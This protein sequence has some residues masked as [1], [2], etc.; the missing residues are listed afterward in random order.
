MGVDCFR[1]KIFCLWALLT[2]CY[3]I[4][5]FGQ[6]GNEWIDYN[7]PYFKI[8]VAKKGI[9]RL[10]AGTLLAAGVPSGIDPTRFQLFH[11]GIEQSI[12]VS[13]Q[14]NGQLDPAD[15]IEF[16]GLANDGTQD[17]Q[18][19]RP[20][21]VQPHKY[22]NLFS[23]TTSYFLTVGT[24]PGKRMLNFDEVNTNGQTSEVF[25]FDEKL[26]INTSQYS[27][28]LDID[29]VQSTFF[30]I[31][32]GWTG[33]QLLQGQ[34]ADYVFSGI[35]VVE[36]T[37]GVP[38]IEVLLVGRGPM[39]HR[40]EIYAGTSA[41]LVATVDF[42]GFQSY[43]DLLSIAWSDIAGD[44]TLPI[45][46]KCV[47][48]GSDPDRISA[49]Y[50]KL[51]YSQKTD[52]QGV[53]EKYF[54]LPAN[55]SGKSYLDIINAAPGVRMFDVT[56]PD[57]AIAIGSIAA[58]T[59][60]AMVPTNT[61]RN[62]YASNTII[63][64]AI[65]AVSFR[66]I[67]P[68]QHNY[69]IISHPFLRQPASGYS[70]PVAAY[71][72]Y[73]ASADGGGYDTLVVHI[74]Q[75]Y[76]QF[77][78][79]EQSPLAVFHFMKFLTDVSVPKYLLLIGKG[80]D[81]SYQYYRSP[82]AF[83]PYHDFVP[84]AGSP[85]SDMAFT[86]GMG[87]TT[88]EPAVPTGRI[89]AVKSE[90][91][92]AYLNKVKEM[93]ALPY[94]D[95]WRK[96]LIHL[97][98]GI[99]EGE[100][101]Q[102]KLDMQAFQTV[103]ED[104]YLGGKVSALAKHSKEI[105]QINIAEQVNKGVN[106]ITFLGHASPTLLDFEL[107]YVTDPVQGYHNKGKYPTLLMNG[108]QVGA[109]FLN[110]TLFGED[111]LVAKDRGA[112][113]FIAHSAYGFIGSLKKYTQTFYEVGY[114]DTTFLTK[115]LGDIQKETARRY[116]LTSEVSSANV[117]QVQQMVLLGD[118][119]VRLFGA[120]K[121]DLEINDNHV[122][123]HSFNGQPITA[124]T[125]SFAVNMIVRNFGQATKDTIRV[126]I[127]RT[128]ND[129]TTITY[130]SL[131]P[132]TKYSDTLTYIIRKAEKQGFGNNT[133][134]ITIDP[135]NILAE[136]TKA[137]N[138]ASKILFISLNGTKNLYPSDFAIVGSQSVSL[139]IQATDLLSGEREFHVEL[140]TANSFDSPYHKQWL[141]KGKV[142]ARQPVTLLDGDTVVYYWR[143]KLSE[144]L[145]NE[146]QE[147]TQSSFTYIK[148]GPE[149]WAQVQFPQYLKNGSVGL[150]KDSNLRRL[151]FLE[152]TQPVEITTFASQ[153]PDYYNNISVKIS[154][155][156]YFAAFPGFECRQ[157]TLNLVAFDRKS[158]VPYLGVKLEWFNR[159]GRTCGRDPIVINNYTYAE[160]ATGTDSDLLGYIDNIETGDSVLLFTIGNAYFSLWPEAAKL[161]LG[162]FG[163][164][165]S[166]INALEDDEPVIIYGRK[167]DA[168]GT[169]SVNRTSSLPK[170][171]Q[172]VSVARTISGGYSSG[173]MTSDW[174]GP[175]IT[176][177]SLFVNTTVAEATDIVAVNVVGIKLDGSEQT[178]MQNVSSIKYLGD[179]SASEYPYIKLSFN[180]ADETY[181]TSA[182]L[183]KWLVTFTPCPEGILFY[184]GILEQESIAEGVSWQGLYK[185]VN[186]TDKVFSDS[187][188]VRYEVFN[189]NDFTAIS[190]EQKITAPLPGDT[191]A[192][193]FDVNTTGRGGLNDVNVFVNPRILAEQYYDNNLLQLN[194]HL[195]VVVDGS[196]PV[197]DVAVDGRHLSDL[198]FVSPSP[199]IV[200]KIWD[201]NKHILKID[202][203][204]VRL[205]LTYPCNGVECPPT[206]I[207]LSAEDVSWYP[208]TDTS[209]F[210]VEFRPRN[211][212]DGIYKLRV[213]GA[214]ARGNTSG[215]DPY[216]ISFTVINETTVNISEP[217]PN[218]FSQQVFIDVSISGGTLP[219][220]FDLQLINVNGGLVDQ[221][222]SDDFPMVH[223]GTNELSWNG[224]GTNGNALPNGVYIYRLHLI[225]GD[226]QVE[227]VGKLVMVR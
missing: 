18:L 53:G 102:F 3:T 162:E 55:P 206:Q 15:Y 199:I 89:T 87:G 59:L 161:K 62:V 157:N 46:I 67:F 71:A 203:T 223:I 125:D 187:L 94:D 80:L 60:T 175:A 24:L 25:H 108:C 93:E 35:D 170:D 29:E 148:N 101:Q 91:V 154:N 10:T 152:S 117:T 219:S 9:Y 5:S 56:D 224:A 84:T 181:L 4:L 225:I 113:G 75:L 31:G 51:K 195:D 41:R 17:G 163:I 97:S 121:A 28:G 27:G 160:M 57:N 40:V 44:G 168:P 21:E 6:T 116:M 217:H 130:D 12:L 81:L 49:S 149:G 172:S 159:A 82:T 30:D 215:I 100:P 37:G 92:A 150:V 155:V 90:D 186:I 123:F 165:L 85:G 111:W 182:Q 180:T 119:A 54:T 211:L 166:Q 77:N 106:L 33:N 191:T 147:W 190:R 140:D 34:F 210:K 20:A 184:D 122:S 126:A 212:A 66:K 2:F 220:Y 226:L 52:M 26:I 141:V 83:M 174:I 158:T 178:L 132:V 196:D 32:E 115:G 64:P 151:K 107:G 23:D 110:Y 169:A 74:Q 183:N 131:F 70:D 61:T 129:N 214:D 135:D 222:T 193:I 177:D 109:F 14:D 200:V 99:Y 104:N 39:S 79:G 47:G 120:K 105:Q 128:L 76:D 13:G 176:W 136:Y 127:L 118:P 138:V 189:Q 156:E 96:N 188:T 145:A 197:L 204:G 88:Y 114:Q 221:F 1:M 205:F 213:E 146:S 50:V 201:E 11:R 164:S 45:R 208:A 134:T 73:R 72:G 142:L 19:Y 95:L 137:N 218:P 167:G 86:A 8:P 209:A 68:A 7:Q 198:D 43:R 144:P 139:S 173:S 69:I 63:V 65:K 58:A 179:I 78:Y 194:S 216:E 38:E 153:A 192:F 227:R 133:F 202:T 171:K 48:S 207:L 124:A 98:G 36:P 112:V 16:Y 42:S 143:T 103:A 185:F 22:Y